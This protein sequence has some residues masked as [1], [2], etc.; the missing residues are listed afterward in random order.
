MKKQGNLYIFIYA[1]VLV[2][3]VAAILSFT[4][5]K[6]KPIQD[7]NV[8]IEKKRDILTSVNIS[9]TVNDAEDLFEKYIK[10][11]FLIN[12]NG[13]KVDGDAFSANLKTEYSKPENERAL[14]LYKAQIEDATFLIIPL[15]GKGLWGPIWGYIS[16]K[17]EVKTAEKT[18]YNYITDE[19]TGDT[20]RID[21]TTS[22][23]PI[24]R[25]YNS[26]AGATFDHK[27]ETPGLGADINK[28]WFEQPFVGKKIFDDNGEFVS[29]AVVKGG[30]AD[31][32]IHGVDAISGGTI[33][34]KGL[35]AML[36]DCLGNYL[37]YI[38]NN[39]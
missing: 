38:K 11:A 8:E 25:S 30:A 24:G 34:S 1:S 14:P 17:E 4:A 26:V 36:K 22:I 20:L 21:T 39:K 32:D 6:L 27:G 3:V 33:T 29:I 10:E 37:A 16:F 19:K 18:F 9:S 23:T 28:D 5:I 35:E 2:I 31:G 12:V 7:K 13:Q 15:R